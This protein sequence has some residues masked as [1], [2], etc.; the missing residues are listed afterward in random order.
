MAIRGTW[1]IKV[2][3]ISMA[4]VKFKGNDVLTAGHLP[5]VGNLA[6]DF[7][8]VAADLATKSLNGFVGKKKIIT[9][10]PSYDTGVCQ[11]AAHAFNQKWR[12]EMMRSS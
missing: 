1:A 9:I 12:Q 7:Q 4:I 11:K 2:A 6:P 10:H 3:E 8:L 5:S